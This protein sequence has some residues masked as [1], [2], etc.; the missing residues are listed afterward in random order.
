MFQRIDSAAEPVLAVV[1]QPSFAAAVARRAGIAEELAG[2]YL[3]N[4]ASE[5]RYALG[6]LRHRRLALT[7]DAR[8]LEVGAGIGL[9]A[10]ILQRAGLRITAIEPI[11]DGFGVFAHL[12]AELVERLPE[13]APLVRCGAE[14]LVPAKHGEFDVIFS[15]N[16]LEHCRPMQP[17]L[18]GI[19]S[20]LAPGGRML[21]LCPNYRVPYEPHLG[22]PL[23]PFA[24]QL[25][26]RLWPAMAAH[27][28][29]SSLNFITAGD[30]QR[31]ARD[32]GLQLELVPGVMDELVARLATDEAF[33]RRQRWVGRIAKV[34]AR[35]GL[36]RVLPASWQSPM[37][38]IFQRP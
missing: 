23:I 25:T 22:A 7:E 1:M 21:H 20:V 29:W 3:A 17:A 27:E 10:T 33:G 6:L 35:T 18:R 5:A 2:Q 34:V 16:V 32:A 24:P 26:P 9:T 38:A 12:R 14:E 15:I 31:L 36:F 37:I 4:L 11:G 28:V 13:A 19:A 30:L 8:V